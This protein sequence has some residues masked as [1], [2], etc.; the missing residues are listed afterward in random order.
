MVDSTEL[1]KLEHVLQSLGN[2]NMSDS[3]CVRFLFMIILA[4]VASCMQWLGFLSRGFLPP[5]T[6][7]SLVI[8]PHSGACSARW[9]SAHVSE[10]E[11][12]LELIKC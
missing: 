4:M 2:I 7:L 11:Q 12:K 8:S 1:K 3:N 10:L 5:A 6:R 9:L